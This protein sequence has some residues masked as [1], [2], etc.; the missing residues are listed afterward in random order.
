[1]TN[2][3]LVKFVEELN[4]AVSNVVIQHADEAL[5]AYKELGGKLPEASFAE[6]MEVSHLSH[7]STF[8]NLPVLS[9]WHR[10]GLN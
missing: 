1:M 6:L 7:L 9:T 8:C 2:P 3:L 10:S 4:N 5:D